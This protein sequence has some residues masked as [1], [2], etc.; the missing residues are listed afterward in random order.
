LL[1]FTAC[2]LAVPGALAQAWV[3]PRGVGSVTFLYQKI[4][5]T[6]HRLTDGSEFE[7]VQSSTHAAYVEVDYALTDRF[8]FSAGIPYVFAR[9]DDPNPPPPPLPYLPV[10]ECH[11]WNTGWQ[12]FG[13]T[14]RYNLIDG[15]FAL[16]P[17]VSAG[18][19]S[20]GYDF[21]GEAALGRQLKELRVAIDAGQRLDAISPRLSIQGRYSY[22]FVERAI[23]I[24][25]NRSNASFETTYLLSRKLAARGFVLW[26]RTHGGLRFPSEVN[27]DERL[28]QHDRLLR[29]NHWSAG[30]GASYSFSRV[31]VFGSYTAFL[32]G[33]DAHTGRTFTFGISWP[34]QFGSP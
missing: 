7:A 10:D 18:T 1:S 28:Y 14:A 33:T 23:D 11:C 19:P 34:F 4:R 2:F 24:S 29:D 17:S 31:D 5:Y 21:R 16:T 30:G 9:Y 25:T 12:D 20:H 6:G 3:A 13:F 26:Q 27:T 22:A 15:P 32:R 8:S